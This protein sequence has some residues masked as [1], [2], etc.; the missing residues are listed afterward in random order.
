MSEE[1]DRITIEALSERVSRLQTLLEEK[2]H[3]LEHAWGV[4][5]DLRATIR[6][7]HDEL[8]RV[9]RDH[10]A[11]WSKLDRAENDL[12]IA[13]DLIK[14][15]QDATTYQKAQDHLEKYREMIRNVIDAVEDFREEG[16]E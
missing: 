11:L 3:D 8:E 12:A 4:E 10:Y 6:Q 15:S 14:D 13:R 2:G 5:R 1:T 9:R 7:Q 16:E